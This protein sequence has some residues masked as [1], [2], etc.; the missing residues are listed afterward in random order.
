MRAQS[1]TI[2]DEHL[3][4]SDQRSSSELEF[5][6]NVGELFSAEGDRVRI[7]VLGCYVVR[8]LVRTLEEFLYQIGTH[9]VKRFRLGLENR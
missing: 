9:L 4:L 5:I 1:V 7:T 8:Q 6:K 2:A 3:A